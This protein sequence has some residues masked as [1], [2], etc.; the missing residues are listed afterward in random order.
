MIV[1]DLTNAKADPNI[2]EVNVHYDQVLRYLVPFGKKL[3]AFITFTTYEVLEKRENATPENLRLAMIMAWA[4]E[5]V[6]RVN[7]SLFRQ[8]ELIKLK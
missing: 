6:S 4:L 5:M 3:R 1:S 7:F 2:V 8:T